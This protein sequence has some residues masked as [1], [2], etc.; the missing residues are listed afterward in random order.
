M[1]TKEA[2]KVKRVYIGYSSYYCIYVSVAQ[3]PTKIKCTLV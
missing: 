1:R 3:V 2:F